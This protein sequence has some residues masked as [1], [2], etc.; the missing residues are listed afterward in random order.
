MAMEIYLENKAIT[1][2]N[3][4]Q[5]VSIK[6]ACLTLNNLCKRNFQLVNKWYLY[7]ESTES[8][9]HL[10]LHCALTANIWNIFLIIFSFN[11]WARKSYELG[12]MIPVCIFWCLWKESNWWF[13][14]I[15]I[16]NHSLK[17]KCLFS[18]FCWFN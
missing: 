7:Q 12:R 2:G 16:P 3:M 17:V 1:K 5:L 9:N 13:D 8:V 10:L 4:L 6:N 11:W 15:L 14:G 18:L